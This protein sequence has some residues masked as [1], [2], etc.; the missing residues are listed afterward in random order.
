MAGVVHV[1]WY[2]TGFRG[3]DLEQALAEIAAVAPRYRA[4]SY[5]LF[6]YRDDRYKFLQTAAFE[7]KL[8]WDRYWLG[9]EFI[10]FRV[11]SQGWFQVPVIYQW[12][13][14]VTA[15]AIEPLASVGEHGAST[16]LR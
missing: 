6:R 8:D 10:D 5:Q 14:L 2:A 9:P 3:A 12:T 15:G 13:D 11:N 7:D 1:P 4:T 16:D